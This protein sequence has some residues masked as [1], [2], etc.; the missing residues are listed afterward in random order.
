VAESNAPGYKPAAGVKVVQPNAG[1]AM[2]R[3]FV[4]G[5][6]NDLIEDSQIALWIHGHGHDRVGYHIGKTNILS[7]PF[8]YP[9]E[10]PYDWHVR[11]VEVL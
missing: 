3:F 8:G 2:N 9:H 10:V 4:G 6:F 7:N 1:S 5:E 11:V